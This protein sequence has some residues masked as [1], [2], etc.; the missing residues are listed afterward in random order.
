MSSGISFDADAA[1]GLERIYTTPDVVA[2]RVRV[3]EALALRPGERV[4][5]VGIGPGLLAYDLAATV[6][7]TG[8]AAGIDL[9]EAMLEMTR[10]RCAGQPWTDFR[11]A[12][13]TELPFEAGEF[14][15]VVSTQVFEYVT[16]M[17]AA[18]SEAFRVLRSGG[19]LLIL[20][21]D[22][23][24]VVWNTGDHARMRR[25]L[26]TWEDHLHDPHLPATLGPRLEEAGFRVDRREVIPIINSDYHRH[27]YSFG[28]MFAIQTF[29]AGRR[30]VTKD[31]ADAW[32][33]ELR[34]LG[35]AGEYFFSM[36]RYLFAA[37]KP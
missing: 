34:A 11:Q 5:D 9:S 28:I 30:D 23:D 7:E 37:S 35:Q 22:W 20:D 17:K 29:V 26:D 2:Q 36:N 32:A 8:L 18:L 27:S 21:T 16:D 13:A 19:R 6:G 33:V 1:R 12:N 3:L 14:D 25:I 10:A 24:S 15:A 31:E 4:L